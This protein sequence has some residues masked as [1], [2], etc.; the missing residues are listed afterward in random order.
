MIKYLFTVHFRFMRFSY[1][2]TTA[3]FSFV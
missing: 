2:S 1:F 3:S